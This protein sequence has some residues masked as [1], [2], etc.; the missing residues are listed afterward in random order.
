LHHLANNRNR[1]SMIMRNSIFL[2][3]LSATTPSCT[4]FAPANSR[5]NPLTKHAAAS[6]DD[7]PAQPPK[8][9]M[10]V[11]AS[12]LLG[13]S[14][15]F[16]VFTGPAEALTLPKF[17]FPSIAL[18]TI[19]SKFT[20]KEISEEDLAFQSLEEE[21]RQSEKELQAELKKAKLEQKRKSFFDYDAKMAEEQEARIEA[22]ERQAKTEFEQEKDEVE[23]LSLLEL[24]KE[25]ELK[26][27]ATKKEKAEKQREVNALLKKEK[28]IA[29]KERIAQ[30][31]EKVFLAEQEQEKRILKEKE[32]AALKEK[33][34]FEKLRMEVDEE[35]ELVGNEEAELNLLKELKKKLS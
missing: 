27:A 6:N 25:R 11:A 18:T 7:V 29:R 5:Q 20:P 4:A 3:L 33:D 21:T 22:I 31:R 17:Q 15:G 32:D 8:D 34:L 16:T 35:K 1:S 23:T 10:K 9:M 13:L 14:F 12:T 19:A 26:L 28:E 30:R 2:V 24:Q